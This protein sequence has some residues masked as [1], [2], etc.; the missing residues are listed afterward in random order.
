MSEVTKSLEHDFDKKLNVNQL[1]NEI[2]TEAGITSKCSGVFNS[3]DEVIIKFDSSLSTEELT[4]LDELIS[5]YN[6]AGQGNNFCTVSK[7]QSTTGQTYSTVIE[8]KTQYLNAGRYIIH[9][10]YTFK[11][12]DGNPDIRIIVDDIN[13]VHTNNNRISVVS[14]SIS[15]DKTGFYSNLILEEGVHNIKIQFKV[16]ND[17]TILDIIQASMYIKS[18]D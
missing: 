6:I 2:N 9:W 12:S 10:Y 1:T 14:A 5:N 15:Y 17:N 7:I 13:V 8:Q 4:T 18:M 11:S 3:E 16:I